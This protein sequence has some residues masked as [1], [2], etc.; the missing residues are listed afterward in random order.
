MK[1]KDI[2]KILEIININNEVSGN[3]LKSYETKCSESPN[4]DWC[5]YN[6]DVSNKFTNLILSLVNCKSDNLSI[7]LN[8]SGIYIRSDDY[9]CIRKPGRGGYSDENNSNISIYKNGF[10]ITKGYT[11]NCGFHDPKMFDSVFDTFKKAITDRHSHCFDSINNDVMKLFNR[12][13]NLD[14]LLGK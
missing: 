10:T 8:E 11:R 14:E 3:G 4:L 5:E 1:K 6:E 9:T 2:R 12:E 7:S 13:N